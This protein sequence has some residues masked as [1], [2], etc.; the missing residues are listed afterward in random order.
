MLVCY[1]ERI[2]ITRIKYYTNRKF[3]DRY[4]SDRILYRWDIHRKTLVYSLQTY[5]IKQIG[6]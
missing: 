1:T 4:Y 3:T 6:Y 5:D 2:N